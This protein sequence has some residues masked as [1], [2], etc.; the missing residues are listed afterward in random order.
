LNIH[1]LLIE[2]YKS[3]QKVEL[4]NPRPFT[5]FVGSNASGK[6]NIFEA[7]HFAILLTE[8]YGRDFVRASGDFI[9]FRN[10]KSLPNFKVNF[11][12]FESAYT[13]L[14]FDQTKKAFKFKHSNFIQKGDLAGTFN[15]YHTHTDYR[16]FFTNFSRI[17]IGQ[18]RFDHRIDDDFRLNMSAKNIDKVLK[19]VL[20]DKVKYEE[21][22]QWL[23][24]FI[25]GLE[26]VEIITEELSDSTNLLVYERGTDKPFPKRLLSDGTK[27]ILSILTSV[28]QS[29][30]PQF[31]CIEEPENGLN[32]KVIKELVSFF[33]QQ[34][35]EKGHYVWLNTHSQTLVREL[36]PEEIIIVDKIDGETRIKQIA[37]MNLHGLKMDDALLS[38]SIGGGIPW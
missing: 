1:R 30:E 33:R 25:P 19:R 11:H 5:V 7:L 8:Y 27:N 24:L 20:A 2:N 12:D 14:N 32:P 28:F 18:D 23:Q 36:T 13:M 35:I 16:Q 15:N 34:C 29:D 22:H 6:S 37:G 17:F 10:P 4:L 9:P 21:I 31:L 3:I 26:R 38:N